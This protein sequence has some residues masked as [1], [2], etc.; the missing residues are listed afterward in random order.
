M[1]TIGNYISKDS[2]IHHLH[3]LTKNLLFFTIFIICL[4]NNHPLVLF[5]IFLGIISIGYA[6]LLPVRKALVTLSGIALVIIIFSLIV[7]PFTLREGQV[8]GNLGGFDVYSNGI[9]LGV[10]MSLRFSS[11]VLMSIFWFMF[12]SL[13]EITRGFVSMKV[14]YKIA[15][16]FTMAFRLVPMA[17]SDITT[18]ANAQ[19]SR[20]LELEKGSVYQRLKKNVAILIPLSSRLVGMLQP[21]SIALESRGFG[22]SKMRSYYSDTQLTRKDY[23]MLIS[24][25]LLLIVSIYLRISGLGLI[26]RSVL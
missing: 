12:T 20:G 6:A 24:L 22:S 7:W 18:I 17:I 16:T 21:M 19:K 1:N 9:W 10:S 13:S 11:I 4:L 15:F 23:I 8:V 14:P 3:P 2:T 25:C 5:F 26:T